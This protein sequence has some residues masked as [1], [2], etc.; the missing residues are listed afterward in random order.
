[1]SRIKEHNSEL[2][3]KCDRLKIN[4]KGNETPVADAA[5]LV[6]IAWLLPGKKAASFKRKGAETV[7]RMLGGDLTLVD[8]IQRK[9][10]QVVGTAEQGF[11]LAGNQG[12]T[13][14]V[15]LPELPHT[16]EQLQQMQ[17]A[18]TAIIAN[19]E[20]VQ[21]CSVVLHDFPMAKYTQYI[22]LRGQEMVLKEK[23]LDID[24]KRFGLR[25]QEDEH[26]LRMDREKAELEDRSAK[27]RRFDSSTDD[28][29]TFRS[30]LAK[31]AE[32]ASD[33]KGFE[34]KARQLS[35][36]LEVYKAFKEQI[37]GNHRPLHYNTEAAEAIAKFITESVVA[38]SKGTAKDLRSYFNAVPRAE[39]DTGDLYDSP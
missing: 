30:L 9:H 23:D 13:A 17:A 29:I 4:N 20:G 3:P 16:L 37:T 26:S 21:Q 25:Q 2:I 19:K 38:N 33:A 8:E 7:C 34:E 12:N 27:R 11:L 24:S 10:A 31:A 15:A 22:E 36:G 35:L 18:A 14:Q 28:G 39:V 1:M 6:E 32:G 5:T